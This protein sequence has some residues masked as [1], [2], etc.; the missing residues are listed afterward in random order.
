MKSD[1][2][3]NTDAVAALKEYIRLYPHGEHVAMAHTNLQHLA[4][5]PTRSK[6]R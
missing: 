5:E 6:K 2:P 1:P 4:M 3:H